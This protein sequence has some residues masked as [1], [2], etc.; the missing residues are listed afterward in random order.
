MS[1]LAA[2]AVRFRLRSCSQA[3]GARCGGDAETPASPAFPLAARLH[4][5]RL[6]GR[7]LPRLDLPYRA[8]LLRRKA[9]GGGGAGTASDAAP[10]GRAW[11]TACGALAL[12]IPACSALTYLSFCRCCAP[13]GA[14]A[15]RGAGLPL[16]AA[17]RAYAARLLR[18]TRFFGLCRT[19]G[20]CILR[21]SFGWR[22]LLF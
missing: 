13:A 21:L 5:A 14:L 2:R 12:G 7:P 8:V 16:T 22:P 9:G 11:R 6:T 1:R 4:A 17:R 20:A 18:T 15:L 10:L 19:C 3:P